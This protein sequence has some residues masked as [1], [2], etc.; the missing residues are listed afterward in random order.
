[1]S[2]DD[3]PVLPYAGTSGHAGSD[4]SRERAQR[5]DNDGTTSLRQRRALAEIAARGAYGAT[6][7]E[8][9]V[10]VGLHH[11]QASGVLSVLHKEGH[12]ARLTHRRDR[13]AVYVLPRFVNGRETAS[14]GRVDWKRRALIA[15][16]QIRAVRDLCDTR[17]AAVFVDDVLRRLDG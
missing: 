8:L 2:A 11:G 14:H 10:I 5:D 9:A 12:L 1:M 7:R 4:T 15:E 16:A 13:C 17:S 6:W 3:L